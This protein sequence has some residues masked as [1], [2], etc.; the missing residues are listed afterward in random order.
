MCFPGYSPDDSRAVSHKVMNNS[1]DVPSECHHA[2]ICESKRSGGGLA[3]K[4][5]DFCPHATRANPSSSFP[6]I[7]QK[8][9]LRSG[10]RN[11][12]R[13][14]SGPVRASTTKGKGPLHFQSDQILQFLI[15][16]LKNLMV[17]GSASIHI[18]RRHSPD[19]D[20]LSGLWPLRQVAKTS[21]L[22][23]VPGA[24]VLPRSQTCS[25]NF[26]LLARLGASILGVKVKVH[27]NSM[28]HKSLE[29]LWFDRLS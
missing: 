7:P 10:N 21:S 9:Y 4:E 17:T 12:W 22:R 20:S 23:D 14:S 16:V 24:R 28:D 29:S 8:D 27:S 3:S 19:K 5:S 2:R 25:C 11:H 15:C 6:Q 18:D 13:A 1:Q 26:R